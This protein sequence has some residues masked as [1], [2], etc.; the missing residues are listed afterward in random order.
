MHPCATPRP[1]AT[2]RSL[3]SPCSAAASH[4]GHGVRVFVRGGV[5]T[6]LLH[7]TPRSISVPNSG[8]GM[9]RGKPGA[10]GPPPSPLSHRVSSQPL[11]TIING[12]HLDGSRREMRQ[13]KTW[14]SGRLWGQAADKSPRGSARWRGWGQ[15]GV[16]A[17]GGG[18]CFSPTRP[19]WGRLSPVMKRWRLF[20]SAALFA[21]FSHAV[22]LGGG[23]GAAIN[24]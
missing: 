10:A 7:Q 11:G 22:L 6:T 14:Q 5:W 23:G 16:Y 15:G 18:G 17:G 3:P 21:C 13:P 9:L 1:S 24:L 8:P 20:T 12:E 4:P 19:P 2:A